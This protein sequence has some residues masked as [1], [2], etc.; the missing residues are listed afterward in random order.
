[1]R[2]E[3][4]VTRM[5]VVRGAMAA[6]VAARERKAMRRTG[7]RAAR[8][9][10]AAVTAVKPGTGA[11]ICTLNTRGGAPY[12]YHI[13]NSKTVY[14]LNRGGGATKYGEIVDVYPL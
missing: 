8:R 1:M 6:A 11:R 12:L 4:M 7:E 14:R 9:A 2:R 10:A 13:R 3:R 5:A